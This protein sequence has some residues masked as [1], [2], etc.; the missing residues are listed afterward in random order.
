MIFKES[1][2]S[3]QK[4]G[5]PQNKILY[6]ERCC[7]AMILPLSSRSVLIDGRFKYKPA[8]SHPMKPIEINKYII[9]DPQ[10]CHGKLTFKDTRIM[11]WQILEMLEAGEPVEKILK[12]HPSLT[13]EHVKA[14]LSYAAAITKGN[15]CVLV[16]V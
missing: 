4:Q 13:R 14:A 1:Y 15:N 2:S 12:E 9:A 3:L 8:V 10:I 5:W 11:V 7:P 6:H 16:N